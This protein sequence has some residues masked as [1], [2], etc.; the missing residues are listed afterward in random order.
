MSGG[1]RVHRRGLGGLPSI[2]HH[3]RT[4]WGAS[5]LGG[6]Q[7]ASSQPGNGAL[8]TPPKSW[9]DCGFPVEPGFLFQGDPGKDGVGKP[10][11]PGPPGAPGPIIYVPEQDVRTQH[12]WACVLPGPPG[13]TL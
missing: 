10:G 6:S 4:L 7:R 3:L 11:P 9:V 13:A 1:L 2:P 8:G 5:R 12:G